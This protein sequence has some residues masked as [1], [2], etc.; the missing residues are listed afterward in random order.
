MD[1]PDAPVGPWAHRFNTPYEFFRVPL[2]NHLC[3]HLMSKRLRLGGRTELG[4]RGLRLRHGADKGEFHVLL[5]KDEYKKHSRRL[6]AL[7]AL[8]F[9]VQVVQ[10]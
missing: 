5:T 8:D 1:D 7:Y 4:Q 6:V 9:D 3:P 10:E 2:I